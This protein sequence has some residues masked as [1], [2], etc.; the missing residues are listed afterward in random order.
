MF[1]YASSNFDASNLWND[2]YIRSSVRMVADTMPTD[3]FASTAFT[4][5]SSSEIASFLSGFAHLLAWS[6]TADRSSH[7]QFFMF[8]SSFTSH[9]RPS[10][11]LTL[12][13]GIPFL[14]AMSIACPVHHDAIER[15][16]VFV[17]PSGVH[18][19]TKSTGVSSFCPKSWLVLRA[20]RSNPYHPNLSGIGCISFAIIRV[21]SLACLA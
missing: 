5:E 2:W 8:F 7:S 1:P 9:S 3:C 16:D 19:I 10:L 17:T 13:T 4:L 14:D 20:I 11:L 18:A 6:V 21:V 12:N 15:S